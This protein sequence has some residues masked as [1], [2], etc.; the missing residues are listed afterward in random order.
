QQLVGFHSVLAIVLEGIGFDL[1]EQSDAAAFL[2]HVDDDASPLPGYACQGSGELVPTVAS[3]GSQVHT[4]QALGVDP[5]KHRGVG[6]PG[7]LQQ[8]QMSFVVQIAGV[9]LQREFAVAGGQPRA[10]AAV[11]ET[12]V[13]Q[14]IGNEIGNRYQ[15]EATVPGQPNEKGKLR[16]SSVAVE[17]FTEDSSRLKPGEA[18]QV[19][20]S[21]GGPGATEQNR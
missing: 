2:T 4:S 11:H 1:I 15:F 18:G 5:C 8:C 7:A 13:P 16:G 21:H 20:S 3:P 19:Q 17:E 10:G 9:G 12:V 6:I 14:A